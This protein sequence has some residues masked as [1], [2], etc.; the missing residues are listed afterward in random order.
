M[1]WDAVIQPT[2]I[3]IWHIHPCSCCR[4]LQL[5]DASVCVSVLLQC[6]FQSEPYVFNS[7]YIRILFRPGKRLN[8]IS[9][10]VFYGRMTKKADAAAVV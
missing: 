3:I 1:V 8:F 4:S 6:V 5:L 2:N 7:V 9:E 10:L